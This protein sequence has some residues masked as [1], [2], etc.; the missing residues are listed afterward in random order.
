MKEFKEFNDKLE[1]GYNDPKKQNIILNETLERYKDAFI[2]ITKN[3]ND[4]IKENQY[5]PKEFYGLIFCYLN[6]YDHEIFL[7]LF[8]KLMN[9]SKEILFEILILYCL[10]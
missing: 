9:N 4:I 8:K 2:E 6:N 1:S 5:N 10:E 3:S 7:D